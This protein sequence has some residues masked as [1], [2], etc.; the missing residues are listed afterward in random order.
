MTYQFPC[1]DCGVPTPDQGTE[2]EAM[3][4]VRQG[5]G[6]RLFA[7]A[8]PDVSGRDAPVPPQPLPQEPRA[9][10]RKARGATRREGAAVTETGTCCRALGFGSAR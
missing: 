8:L 1:T 3:R 10:P 5:G 2:T 4:P 9:H 6:A 7:L